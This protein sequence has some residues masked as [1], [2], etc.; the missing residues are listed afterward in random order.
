MATNITNS[1]FNATQEKV[2]TPRL[3]GS[4]CISWLVMLITECLATAILNIITIIVFMKQ[5]QLQRRSTYLIIHLA[6]V[7]FLVGAVS[8]PLTLAERM[9]SFCNLWKN[10]FREYA[11]YLITHIT[12]P[13][14]IQHAITLLLYFTSILNLAIISLEHTSPTA[15]SSSRELDLR[16][17]DLCH[18]DFFCFA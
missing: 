5:R 6:F 12:S 8:G 3:G 9:A 13:Y 4:L 18:V 7:D 1:T 15:A 10:P 17:G 16:N 2:T 14:I 11:T